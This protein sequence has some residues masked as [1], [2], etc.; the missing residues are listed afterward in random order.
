MIKIFKKLVY[1][2]RVYL[3]FVI[4]L[5]FPQTKKMIIN[6][7]HKLF[8]DSGALH[9]TWKN[10]K[11]L[12]VLVQKC[13]L[14]LFIYQELIFEIKPDLII[15][16]GTAYGGGT[17]FL[18][19]ICEL[20]N[21]GEVVTIDITN[22]ATIPFHNR[23]MQVIGSSTDEKVI[24]QIRELAKDKPKVLVILDSDHSKTHVL[25]EL[26][27]YSKLVS[28]GSYLIVEDT[29][30][31]GHPVYV[32]HGAGSMEAVQEFM[33]GNHDFKIDKSCEK[34]YL[35]FNPSGYLKRI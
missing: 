17:L 26:Q 34:Y 19:S 25:K 32:E 31:N 18:A 12:D 24:N 4:Y 21:N 27:L 6:N 14:D 10:T 30:I 23:I 1:K 15:E 5:F 35:T 22:T 33:K 9:G 3:N 8:Y 20:I 7:F 29:N 2:I 13:P 16:T 11:F 28:K